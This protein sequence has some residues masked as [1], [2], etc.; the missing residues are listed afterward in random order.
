MK[1]EQSK[2]SVYTFQQVMKEVF[3]HLHPIFCFLQEVFS[4][5]RMTHVH[6]RGHRH[7]LQV[8]I[9]L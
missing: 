2:R 5:P 4:Y 1:A 8:D 7:D 6:I 3:E 9:F